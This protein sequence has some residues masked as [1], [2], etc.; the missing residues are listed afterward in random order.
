MITG[1]FNIVKIDFFIEWK[2]SDP[3]KYLFNSIDPQLILRDSSLSAARSVVGST[4]IDDVLTSGKI[5]IENEIKDKLIQSLD[6]YDIGVQVLDVKIQDSEQ[7][8]EE[9]KQ[10]FKAVENAKQSKETAM[11]EA[12]KFKD[13][14]IPKAQAEADRM[15]RS[16]ESAKQTKDK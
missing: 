7:P 13:S 3:K 15:L 2:I 9:V 4:S 11:N 10:A 8:T 16:A 6:E 12:N 1:D 14:K 5:A